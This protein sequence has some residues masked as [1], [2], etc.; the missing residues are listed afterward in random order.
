MNR[1]YTSEA[2]YQSVIKLREIYDAPSL[3]TDIIVGFP[4]ETEAE[5]EDTYAFVK[6]IAFSEIHVFPFSKREG[7]PAA[8]M[9][10]QVDPNV[11][12]QRSER[13]IA[14]GKEMNDVYVH[15][16]ESQIATVLIEERKG[17]ECIGHSSNYLKVHIVDSDHSLKQG[18]I[19]SVLIKETNNHKITGE[20]VK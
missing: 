1:K 14:L 18:E 12:K 17:S 9:E 6:K 15:S 7:T 11:K 20:I 3:T 2:F 8:E 10:Q 13:L 19:Y 5:F 4:G 16:F